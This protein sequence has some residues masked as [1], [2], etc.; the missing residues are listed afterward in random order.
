M[1]D[2]KL[3]QLNTQLQEDK[4]KLVTLKMTLRVMPPMVQITGSAEL[5]ELQQRI[6][7]A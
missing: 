5:K 6:G 3:V 2:E 4:G 1:L 7:K